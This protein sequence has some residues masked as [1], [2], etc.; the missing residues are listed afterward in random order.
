VSLADPATVI[1]RLEEI[2]G[3]LASR[4]QELEDA[5][6]AW[7]RVKRDQ[8]KQRAEAFITADGNS[9]ERRMAADKATT[10]V[11][12]EEEAKYEALRSVVKVLEA[13]ATIGQSLLRA[14]GRGA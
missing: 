8:E 14:Q 7:F 12:K 6:L 3:D 5:A 1:N 2:E 9:T 13:R 10:L 11:G 4:Q